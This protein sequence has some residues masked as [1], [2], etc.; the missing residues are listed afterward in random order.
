VANLMFRLGLPPMGL[1]VTRAHTRAHTHTNTHTH[2]HTHP[3]PHTRTHTHTHT[4]TYASPPGTASVCNVDRSIDCPCD[5]NAT[6]ATGAQSISLSFD[7]IPM[8]W[9]LGQTLP[10]RSTSAP[11]TTTSTAAPTQW[12]Y[13][14]NVTCDVRDIFGGPNGGSGQDLGR[15]TGGFEAVDVPP[16]GSRFLLLSNCKSHL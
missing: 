7:V 3:R 1:L 5:D 12:S 4:S 6:E 10:A 8:Q 16:H 15:F 2:T 9:L 13:A 11:S 14:T